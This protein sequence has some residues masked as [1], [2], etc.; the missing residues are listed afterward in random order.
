MERNLKT[1][2]ELGFI[3]VGWERF[4]P[5]ELS[6]KSPPCH[7]TELRGGIHKNF[8]LPTFG[9]I[10]LSHFGQSDGSK[11]GLI[12]VPICTSLLLKL[13]ISLHT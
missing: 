7:S 10:Q 8:Y 13:D 4:S 3:D 2:F 12:T 11:V 1:R 9:F 5:S 6:L